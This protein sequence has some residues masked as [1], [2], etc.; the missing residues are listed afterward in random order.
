MEVYS[1]MRGV[2]L[3]APRITFFMTASWIEG[4]ISLQSS[5]ICASVLRLIS[6]FIYVYM[7]NIPYENHFFIEV[8]GYCLIIS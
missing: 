2:S 3:A 7:M 1:T 6:A 8:L 5:L 4:A